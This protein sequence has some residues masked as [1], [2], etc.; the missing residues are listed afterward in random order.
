MGARITIPFTL[1]PL[2][3][4]QSVL[5]SEFSVLVLQLGSNFLCDNIKAMTP[6]SLVVGLALEG[7]QTESL[8]LC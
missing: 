5:Q 7:L 6:Y 4:G 1:E 2:L 3:R 8:N